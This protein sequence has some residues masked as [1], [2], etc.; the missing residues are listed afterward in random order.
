L[1]AA[2]NAVLSPHRASFTHESTLR[3]RDMLCEILRAHFA[4]RPVP[5]P[6]KG[7]EHLI[8]KG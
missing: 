7:F 3:M 2:K 4:G 6:V 8:A 1:T 5:N